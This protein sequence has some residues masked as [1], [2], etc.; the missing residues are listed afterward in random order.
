MLAYQRSCRL[1]I[2]SKTGV[3]WM[4]FEKKGLTQ[5]LGLTKV[6]ASP[7]RIHC[8]NKGMTFRIHGRWNKAGDKRL[9]TNSAIS[10]ELHMCISE[11]LQYRN[12]SDHLWFFFS[13][14]ITWYT[15]LAEH[16]SFLLLKI[17]HNKQNMEGM[18]SKPETCRTVYYLRASKTLAALMLIEQRIFFHGA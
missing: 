2:C 5:T 17:M 6:L 15:N 10:T 13:F 8:Y 1:Q 3:G 4:D 9:I 11:T 12:C 18:C 16:T 7:V 14:L